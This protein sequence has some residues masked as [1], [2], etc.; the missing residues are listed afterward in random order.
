M[1]SIPRLDQELFLSNKLFSAMHVLGAVRWYWIK[2]LE[3]WRNFAEKKNDI[4]VLNLGRAAKKFFFIFPAKVLSNGQFSE[5][6]QKRTFKAK[7]EILEDFFQKGKPWSKGGH[8]LQK[9][10]KISLDVF[11]A[12]YF[13]LIDMN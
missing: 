11:G 6:G 4:G 13:Q 2:L 10:L 8:V 9:S 1:C 5:R 12:F 3:F 7:R